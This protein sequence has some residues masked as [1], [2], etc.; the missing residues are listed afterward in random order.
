MSPNTA[1]TAPS[2]PS[3]KMAFSA[4]LPPLVPQHGSWASLSPQTRT[5][6]PRSR[7]RS[8]GAGGRWLSLVFACPVPQHQLSVGPVW[9]LPAPP[10]HPIPS[11][12]DQSP[13]VPTLG[14]HHPP[15]DPQ[16]HHPWPTGARPSLPHVLKL[17]S[18]PQNHLQAGATK[19]T[20]GGTP[21][22]RAAG[23]HHPGAGTPA[24]TSRPEHPCQGL[25]RSLRP[26]LRQR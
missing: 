1:P 12:W 23:T 13:P 3:P 6:P 26:F 8:S 11:W 21:S 15:Q 19:G 20:A 5:C 25:T 22:Q 9:D 18:Y 4:S 17:L 16:D 10:L 7:G 14:T 24:P 2:L